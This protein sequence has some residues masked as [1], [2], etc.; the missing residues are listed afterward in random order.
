MKE[1]GDLTEEQY[2]TLIWNWRLSLDK[3]SGC[4][5]QGDLDKIK[6]AMDKISEQL[7]LDIETHK[8]NLKE[9]KKQPAKKVEGEYKPKREIHTVVKMAPLTQIF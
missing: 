2:E 7:G 9:L 3:G 1:K 8:S 6:K 4:E 5:D